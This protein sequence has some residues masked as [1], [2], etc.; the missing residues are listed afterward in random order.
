M[1]NVKSNSE[2]TT[3]LERLLGG[4]PPPND[5]L[6]DTL[7]SLVLRSDRRILAL[8]DD[9]TGTQTV[10]DTPIVLGRS[11]DEIGWA[12][13]QPSPLSVVVTNSRSFVAQKAGEI[14]A[15]VASNGAVAV[16]RLGLEVSLISRSDSTLRGHFPLEIDT[17]VGSWKD[18]FQ[19]RFDALLFCPAYVEAGR[20]TV[21]GTHFV[22]SSDIAMPVG[23]TEFA[24]DATFG[25]Q[26]S[27]LIDW[28]DEKAPGRFDLSRAASIDL[29]DIRL[30]GV[31]RVLEKLMAL[32][33]IQPVVIDAVVPSDVD[34]V[35]AAVVQAESM[36]KRFV[37]QCGPSFLRARAGLPPRGAL[38]LKGLRWGEKPSDSHGLVVVGS[39]VGLTNQQLE[40]ARD[41]GGFIEIEL[42]VSSL[43]DRDKSAVEITRAIR[44]VTT[45]LR[46]S[47]V[48]LSTSRS[49][50][51]GANA[52]QSLEIAG[53]VSAALVAIVREVISMSPPL[54]YLL[55]KGGITSC[56]VLRESVGFMRGWIAGQVLDGMVSVWVPHSTNK[57]AAL[58]QGTRDYPLV[59]FAGNVGGA[60]GLADVVELLRRDT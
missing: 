60:S 30:G 17:L 52:D 49:L 58:A 27:R 24:R 4:V 16:R 3:S 54:R 10:Y 19:E 14:V 18:A 36:G 31:P 43:V 38:S 48:I 15:E 33:N 42:D 1:S 23:A 51:T 6:G 37:C 35:A 55:T 32:N 8:D 2:G 59:V 7:K 44:D 39:H 56:D 40:Q 11:V 21:Y 13:R 57:L 47:D 45:S 41:L 29:D 12:L 34:V 25:Y 28:I 20:I 46:K 50:V 22:V 26:S 5:L 9:P 53:V